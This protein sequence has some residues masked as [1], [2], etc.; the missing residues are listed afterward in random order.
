MA[1]IRF[2]C[3]Q[4]ELG[5]EVIGCLVAHPM[6]CSNLREVVLAPDNEVCDLFDLASGEA[7]RLKVFLAL[8]TSLSASVDSLFPANELAREIGREWSQRSGAGAL[9]ATLNSADFALW[10][11]AAA[12]LALDQMRIDAATTRSAR[13][14]GIAAIDAALHGGLRIGTLTEI[15]CGAD[16]DTWSGTALC[17]A[18]ARHATWSVWIPLSA[19]AEIELGNAVDRGLS[20]VSADIFSGVRPDASS[21]M[22]LLVLLECEII[23]RRAEHACSPGGIIFLSDVSS[24]LHR[25]DADAAVQAIQ[26]TLLSR[27]KVFAQR[28][29]LCI[30]LTEM[31][32][33]DAAAAPLHAVSARLVLGSQSVSILKCSWA[34]TTSRAIEL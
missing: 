20:S 31:H 12:S 25:A 2:G 22:Q 16:G 19:R 15:S 4:Q 1:A 28:Y 7:T 33:N 5:C 10:C 21:L 8:Y 26:I 34:A 13:P 23:T 18:F 24:A 29:E 11:A 30:V 32:L 3:L 9:A 14:C 27:L 6:N 17:L